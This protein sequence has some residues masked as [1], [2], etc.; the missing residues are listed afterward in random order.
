MWFF[1]K[2]YILK[3]LELNIHAISLLLIN[4]VLYVIME[5]L[6]RYVCGFKVID[7]QWSSLAWPIEM[8][9]RRTFAKKTCWIYH[10]TNH[11]GNY[12]KTFFFV[13]N[14][15]QLLN[16]CVCRAKEYFFTRLTTHSFVVNF[17]WVGLLFHGRNT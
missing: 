6:G 12:N 17:F 15:V 13:L 2:L 4:C 1:V 14:I 10:T 9:K 5:A 7:I 16:F 3:M 11:I 8:I